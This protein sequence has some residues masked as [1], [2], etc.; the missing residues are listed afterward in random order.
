M[1]KVAGNYKSLSAI[2]SATLIF[3][4]LLALSRNQVK[5][6][7]NIS[8][9]NYLG[10]VSAFM[11][12]SYLIK[13]FQS[14]LELVWDSSTLLLGDCFAIANTSSDLL[15]NAKIPVWTV[16]LTASYAVSPAINLH[17]E[18]RIGYLKVLSSKLS[19]G[20]NAGL[21]GGASITENMDLFGHLLY[22]PITIGSIKVSVF[23]M[24]LS[25][26][27]NYY[28]HMPK[29]HTGLE[30]LVLSASIGGSTGKVNYSQSLNQTL[31]FF[32]NDAM[33]FINTMGGYLRVDTFYLDINQ[34]VYYRIFRFL[35]F[36]AGFGL[37]LVHTKLEL[38]LSSGAL[39]NYIPSGLGFINIGE[40]IIEGTTKKVHLLPHL[41]IGCTINLWNVKIPFQFRVS[42]TPETAEAPVMNFT[43][44]L[45]VEF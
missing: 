15:G 3:I 27:W 20:L 25:W 22:L 12:N 40:I 7:V 13:R 31:E 11:S 37:T 9:T 24:G 39:L 6:E 8:F 45:R 5:A 14:S 42:W 23:N 32:N 34:D 29:S 17:D 38:S 41:Q 28:S 4:L 26:R 21:N 30:G 2:K 1:S 10:V 36:T 44:G 43:C 33:L 16:G 18:S 19:F 35:T